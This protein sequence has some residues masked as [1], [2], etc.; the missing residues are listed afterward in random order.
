MAGVFVSVD[1]FPFTLVASP[2]SEEVLLLH[3]RRKS[4][5]EASERNFQTALLLSP[6]L[7]NPVLLSQLER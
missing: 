5:K 6:I 2:P 4:E 7:R 1:S 3:Q